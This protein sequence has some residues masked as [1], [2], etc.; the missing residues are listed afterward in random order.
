ML[1]EVVPTVADVTTVLDITIPPL[2]VAVAFILVADPVC[3]S[4]KDLWI[5]AT[6][7]G[8]R[9]RLNIF[10]YMLGPVRRFLEPLCLKAQL[11]F[12]FS[13]Q[14]VCWWLGD[15]RGEALLGDGALEWRDVSV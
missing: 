9:E 8:A 6:V 11:A 4:L 14:R 12:E 15:V 1:K 5:S 2:E 10:M 7:P 13:G 3:L